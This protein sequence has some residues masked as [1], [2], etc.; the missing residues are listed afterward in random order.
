[1]VQLLRLRLEAVAGHQICKSSLQYINLA[2]PFADLNGCEISRV[3]RRKTESLCCYALEFVAERFGVSTIASRKSCKRRNKSAKMSA[4][5]GRHRFRL[6]P[7][8]EAPC[9]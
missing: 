7:L 5:Y 8:C 6:S 9:D 4:C 3:L 1:K 2:T